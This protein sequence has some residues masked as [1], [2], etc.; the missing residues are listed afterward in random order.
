MNSNDET[1]VRIRPRSL[2]GARTPSHV[3]MSP[4]KRLVV[5]L[6]SFL[7]G[8]RQDTSTPSLAATSPAAGGA[9][10]TPQPSSAHS[11]GS[12]DVSDAAVDA[13]GSTAV[14]LFG[15]DPAAASRSGRF[16]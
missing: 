11:A 10:R 15:S 2:S 4:M 6:R 3:I 13:S 14:S 9:D 12:G 5:S 7:T 1:V 8:K 16:V